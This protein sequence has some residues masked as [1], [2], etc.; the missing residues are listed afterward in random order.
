MP[1]VY[2]ILEESSHKSSQNIDFIK[3]L[4]FERNLTGFETFDYV[5]QDKFEFSLNGKNTNFKYRC[6]VH[7]VNDTTT[8]MS[9]QI[10]TI[11]DFL[12]KLEKLS[13]QEN[14]YF[15]YQLKLYYLYF[16]YETGFYEPELYKEEGWLLNREDENSSLLKM[17]NFEYIEFDFTQKTD[18]VVIRIFGDCEYEQEHGVQI[19]ITSDFKIYD[20]GGQD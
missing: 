11:A 20:V 15:L 18:E 9:K 13:I 1:K 14:W 10:D 8:L 2:I 16:K 19:K 6:S 17:T 7:V 12:F 3:L 5:S 4:N